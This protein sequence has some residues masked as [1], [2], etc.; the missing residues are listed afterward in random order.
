MHIEIALPD[1]VAHSLESK[2]G[3][4]E[5]RL[6]EIVIIEAYREGFISVGKISELLGMS[7]RLEV[8]SFLKAKGVDLLYEES[9]FQADRKTHDQLRQEGKL[10]P[11]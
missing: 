6:L 11:L 5:R 9:D 8:D 2:W 7:T 4:L 3:N 1:E 10:N